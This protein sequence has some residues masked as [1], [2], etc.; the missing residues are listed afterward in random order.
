[1]GR[2]GGGE[3][4][5]DAAA[6]AGDL[7][8]EGDG[9]GGGAGG[10]DG[11]DGDALGGEAVDHV[12]PVEA[13]GGVGGHVR[14]AVADDDE[15]ARAVG[16]GLRAGRGRAAGER[17]CRAQGRAPGERD[18]RLLERP[19]VRLGRGPA[20]RGREQAHE[21]A[22]VRAVAREVDAA[23]G[24]RVAVVAKA[25]RGPLGPRREAAPRDARHE[26]AHAHAQ[27]AQARA[28]RA[29][30]VHQERHLQALRP[31]QRTPAAQQLPLRPAPQLRPAVVLDHLRPQRLRTLPQRTRL[32]FINHLWNCC[33]CC[34]CCCFT[35]LIIVG[36]VVRVVGGGKDSKL[37]GLP[38]LG[39]A[40]HNEGL[41]LVRKRGRLEV[42]RRGKQRHRSRDHCCL[43]L[44]VVALER[45]KQLIDAR[46]FAEA[47]Q[48]AHMPLGAVCLEKLFPCISTVVVRHLRHYTRFVVHSH[49]LLRLL[50]K[51]PIKHSTEVLRWACHLHLLCLVLIIVVVVF[52]RFWT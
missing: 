48:R 36:V 45:C 3:V 43:V 35:T 52:F 13:R 9:G 46:A 29:R 28:H 39:A 14:E 41:Q 27:L 22:H 6:A 44:R 20:A 33:C 47:Q 12:L 4:D 51:A 17:G 38:R 32:L 5:K 31:P 2:E 49:L 42:L 16:I 25:Q 11:S 23:H 1:M 15:E 10:A 26:L 37:V 7:A 18:A 21:A 34:C 40:A 8:E 30:R 24:A 50:L 19:L